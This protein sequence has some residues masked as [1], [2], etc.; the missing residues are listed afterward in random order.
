MGNVICNNN[1]ERLTDCRFAGY[2]TPGCNH[3]NDVGIHCEGMSFLSGFHKLVE[4]D[5]NANI[6]VRYFT[7]YEQTFQ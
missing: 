6:G 5:N 3:N 7:T 4:F 1:E 2:V